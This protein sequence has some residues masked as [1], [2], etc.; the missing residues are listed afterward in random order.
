MSSSKK[1]Y[2]MKTIK[3]ITTALK[4]AEE[5]QDWMLEIEADE[6]AGVQKAW[7]T[8]QKRQDKKRQL[9]KE[10]QAKVAF[11]LSYG[12]IDTLIAGVDEA[13]RGPLAGP[14]VTAAVILPTN[15][16]HLLD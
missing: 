13:G 8:W 4:D 15:C 16:G 5:W 3:E 14:V 1:E 9:Q 10:H 6:R 12:G 7:L 11:D 2:K